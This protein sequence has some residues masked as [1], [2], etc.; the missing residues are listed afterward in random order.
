[1]L[2]CIPVL[3]NRKSYRTAVL[4]CLSGFS[5]SKIIKLFFLLCSSELI[6]LIVTPHFAINMG[7]VNIYTVGVKYCKQISGITPTNFKGL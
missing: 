1:M 4:L 7:A 3:G 2:H 6:V 5:D